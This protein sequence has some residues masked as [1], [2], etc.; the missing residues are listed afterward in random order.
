MGITDLTAKIIKKSANT[1][2]HIYFQFMLEMPLF[3][4]VQYMSQISAW[5]SV[6]RMK[7]LLHMSTV[8]ITNWFFWKRSPRTTPLS[9]MSVK[10]TY[11][12]SIVR[13]GGIYNIITCLPLRNKS[14]MVE[15]LPRTSTWKFKEKNNP[16]WTIQRFWTQRFRP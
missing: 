7:C 8:K 6:I 3:D 4:T 15:Q 1:C 16:T 5:N 10:S 13:K 11:S 12:K 9:A 2:V 14:L